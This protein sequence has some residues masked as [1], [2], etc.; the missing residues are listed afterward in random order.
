MKTR[1]KIFDSKVNLEVWLGKRRRIS[2]GV[3][4]VFIVTDSC[5][6]SKIRNEGTWDMFSECP[7]SSCEF[8]TLTF[9]L[10]IKNAWQHH[11]TWVYRLSEDPSTGAPDSSFN[12]VD[13]FNH[14][15]NYAS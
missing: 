3:I 6:R 4:A 1:V 10:Q 7:S 9:R 14:C 2:K 8:T 13:Y 12:T 11:A 5:Q 15:L